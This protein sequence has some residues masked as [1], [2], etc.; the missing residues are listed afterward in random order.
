MPKI[1][2]AHTYQFLLGKLLWAF[3]GKSPP[4]R[5]EVFYAF[6]LLL[7]GSN[8]FW[9]ANPSMGVVELP[10][11]LLLYRLPNEMEPFGWFAYQVRTA[12]YRLHGEL[13]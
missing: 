5:N 2:E 10:D 3:E 9:H 8:Q 13:Q 12:L 11:K 1:I 6:I 7:L 4:P